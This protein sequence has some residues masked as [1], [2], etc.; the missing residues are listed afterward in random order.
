MN[1]KKILLGSGFIVLCLIFFSVYLFEKPKISV[2]GSKAK[3]KIDA[4]TLFSEYKFN[5][6]QAQSKYF[7]KVI[8]LTGTVLSVQENPFVIVVSGNTALMDGV[9]CKMDAG[10]EKILANNLDN[11]SSNDIK[12]GDTVIIKGIV[13]Q[14]KYEVDLHHCIIMD[15]ADGDH[16]GDGDDDDNNN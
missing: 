13:A 14:Y 6:T 7:D 15:Y 11:I 5:P 1:A 3:Y 16:D 9:H 8:I 12:A 10:Q 2:W 4:V